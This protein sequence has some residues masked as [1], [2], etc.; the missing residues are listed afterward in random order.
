[1]LTDQSIATT[2]S[3]LPFTMIPNVFL[4]SIMSQKLSGSE[5]RVILFLGRATFGYHVDVKYLSLNQ[6]ARQTGLFKSAVVRSLKSLVEK[7]IV[8]KWV[9]PN[10]VAAYSLVIPTLLPTPPVR[11]GN[12]FDDLQPTTFPD[13]RNVQEKIDQYGCVY[14]LVAN[15]I[16]KAT[17][18]VHRTGSVPVERTGSVPV[19][20]TGSVPV[21]RTGSVPVERTGSVPVDRTA[22]NKEEKSN[23]SVRNLTATDLPNWEFSTAKDSD[24][25]PA[26]QT[27]DKFSPAERAE[28]KL[29]LDELKKDNPSLF[30]HASDY[31]FKSEMTDEE[32]SLRKALLNAQAVA[33]A[34]RAEEVLVGSLD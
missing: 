27:V 3:T 17:V 1:M 14:T 5:F 11:V 25:V 33:S 13:V 2:K 18:P 23:K 4:E 6:I 24:A 15:E 31:V 22:L 20:R 16:E 9:K 32:I 7:L 19:E 29:V 8:R 12:L 34:K 26:D 28:I 21:H 10:T 30:R